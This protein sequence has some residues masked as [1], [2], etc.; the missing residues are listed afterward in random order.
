MFIQRCVKGVR[1]RLANA[2]P[3]VGIDDAQARAMIDSGD[4]IRCNWRRNVRQ[5]S[6]AQ[7]RAKLT[8]ANLD[9]HIHGKAGA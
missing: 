8:Q 3:G 6:L 2:D 7:Q 1:S 5:I 4:G 9:R